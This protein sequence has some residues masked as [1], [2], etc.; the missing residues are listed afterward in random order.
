MLEAYW[1]YDFV[2]DRPIGAILDAFN[3]AGPWQWRLHESA[4]Y[5]DYLNCRPM[6]H[7]RVRVHEYL[8]RESTAYSLVRATK[9][10]QLCLKLSQ[11]ARRLGSRSM[12]CFDTCWRRSTQQ[13]WPRLRPT[14]ERV[15]RWFGAM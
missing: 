3:A 1:A 8:R 9:A 10:S 12:A 11:K 7:V 15:Y 6:E 5:G 14:T 2:C 13:I 4:V